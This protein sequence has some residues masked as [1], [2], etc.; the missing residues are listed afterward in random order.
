M[1]RIG[2][3]REIDARNLALDTA[4][5]SGIEADM[6]D[7]EPRMSASDWA[8][9]LVLSV[10][11]GGAFFFISV[12]LRAFQPLTL[13]V[14]R[15]GLASALLW[16]VLRV[17]GG[18]MPRGFA[19][20]RALLMLALL[21]N[22]IPFALFFWAM[23]HI[24]GG[25][26]SIVNATTPI[27]GVIVAHLFTRDE[28]ATPNKVAGVVLGFAG[29]VVMI[30]TDAFYGVGGQVLPQLACVAG[31]LCYAVA[32]VYARRFDAL[33]VSPLALSAGSLAMAA[34]AL[35]PVA[36]LVERPWQAAMPGFTAWA[37]LA[38]LVI[39]SSALAYVLFFRLIASAGATNA[40]LVT[41]LI[42]VTAILLG[43]MVLGE[44]LGRNDFA[45]MALIALGLVAVDGRLPRK[46]WGLL[47]RGPAA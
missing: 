17:R 13:I 21:N 24:S 22:A 14:L 28:K 30:G 19:A 10:L 36:L 16:L 3:S 35:L 38:G 2:C 34:V 46:A 23:L 9:L 39:F 8:V 25:L 20:W 29:V 11:W 31:T 40:M 27:W 12:A 18:R 32:G 45:G 44:R 37:A 41:F 26:A 15:V 1:M 7:A 6:G 33:G 4:T 47:R 42:P 5:A 43:S